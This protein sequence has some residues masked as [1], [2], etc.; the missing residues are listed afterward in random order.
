MIG[1]HDL[2][3]KQ[4]FALCE[5]Q[6]S[7]KR[8]ELRRASF[9]LRRNGVEEMEE[10]CQIMENYPEKLSSFRDVGTKSF[11]LIREVCFIYEQLGRDAIESDVKIS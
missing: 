10:L 9:A 7:L 11:G 8:T 2:E 3:I 1:G 4:F 5:G 6:A